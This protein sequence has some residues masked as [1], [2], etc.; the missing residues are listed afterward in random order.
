[1]VGKI[2]LGNYS[3]LGL[4]GIFT[5]EGQWQEKCEIH[6]FIVLSAEALAS[7]FTTI[8]MSGNPV[9]VSCQIM[10]QTMNSFC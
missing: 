4:S 5:E 6:N 1:M 3:W 2:L 9:D 7:S 8:F 10:L